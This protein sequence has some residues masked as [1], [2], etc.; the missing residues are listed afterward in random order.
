[1]SVI[2]ITNQN[3][4]K[5]VLE[6]DQIVLLDFWA[7]WCGPCKII[8]PVIN[9]IAT[10]HPSIKVCK[11]N[12]DEQPEL[13]NRYHVMSIPSLFI[14]QNGEILNQSVGAKTKEEILNMLHL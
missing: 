11:I 3:Y 9:E 12:V 2:T 6:S 7:P 4:Q 10:E 14:I 5:E 1:M 8:T 13:A